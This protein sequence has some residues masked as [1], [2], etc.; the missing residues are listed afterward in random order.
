MAHNLVCSGEPPAGPPPGGSTPYPEAVRRA[1]A[2]R[3]APSLVG[4]NVEQVDA[5]AAVLWDVISGLGGENGWYTIP[6]VWALRGGLDRLVGGVGA[7]RTRPDQ[8]EPGAAL[9]WWRI[10]EVEEGA[11]LLLRAETRMPG[12]ARL[13][14]RAEPDGPDR[15]RYV[16]RVEFTPD[17][18]AGRVYWYAQRP[19]HDV[20]FGVMARTVAG[21]AGR[22]AR[23]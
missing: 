8:L 17:G 7:R 6:G 11:R 5:P 13:E 21:V 20:I 19:A 10:E 12:T 1:L 2:Q 23:E 15:S 18:L 14:L 16:Q 4:E 9:D 22:R 3:E